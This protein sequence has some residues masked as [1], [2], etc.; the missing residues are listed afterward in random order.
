MEKRNKLIDIMKGA[1]IICVV[2]GHLNVEILHHY[3]FWFHM[4][5]YFM[6][7][8]YLYKGINNKH[9]LNDWAIRKCKRLLVPYLSFGIVILAI[10]IAQE[11][12]LAIIP[13]YIKTIV[14]GGRSLV[15]FYGVFWFVTCLLVTQIVFAYITT[16]IRSNA[17]IISI[18]AI[19]YII[20]HLYSLSQP[21]IKILWSVDT[22]MISIVYYSIGY[23]SKN[24]VDKIRLPHVVI[25]LIVIGSLVILERSNI[26]IYNLDLKGNVYDH[27][28]L[29]L[30]VPITCAVLVICIS[31]WFE[32]KYIDYL[33]RDLGRSSMTIMYLH[34][35]VMILTKEYFQLNIIIVGLLSLL[36]PFGIHFILEQ[37]SVAR[38]LFFGETIKKI[39]YRNQTRSA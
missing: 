29:D 38:F 2:F 37:F 5:L 14:I 26:I 9:T 18:V 7:S 11:N 21:T 34:L 8:G 16:Y 20:A 28:L 23:Y 35:S 19:L 1:G 32:G 4:P 31:K 36:I 15:Y 6:I 24:I 30:L 10:V 13:E 33:L 27:F 22:T 25:S 17:I 39:K 3:L 12:T